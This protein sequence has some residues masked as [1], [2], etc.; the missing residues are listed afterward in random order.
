[1]DTNVDKEMK[2]IGRRI[3][4]L[5]VKVTAQKNCHRLETGTTWR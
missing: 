5:A 2:E 3:L 1:V 4:L